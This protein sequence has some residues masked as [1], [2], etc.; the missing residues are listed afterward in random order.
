MF[1]ITRYKE[2]L[3]GLEEYEV[4]GTDID[5]LDKAVDSLA[6]IFKNYEISG[7]YSLE[8][9]YN[10]EF[11]MI[12][13]ESNEEFILKIEEIIPEKSS[14]FIQFLSGD[15]IE[16]IRSEEAV[17]YQ[18][19]FSG[20]YPNGI[21]CWVSG[22]K[23]MNGKRDL[24][25]ITRVK[26][27]DTYYPEFIPANTVPY[28]ESSEDMSRENVYIKYKTAVPLSKNELLFF[29]EQASKLDRIDM[30]DTCSSKGL[31]FV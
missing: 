5:S 17:G 3:L 20:N 8:E 12:D 31:F 2:T 21:L 6:R 18:K 27:S 22:M 13:F 4:E 1:K 28:Q 19:W 10:N 30:S 14:P 9:I 16:N 23:G 24:A 29:A 15:N 11:T 7:S 25:L 26:L